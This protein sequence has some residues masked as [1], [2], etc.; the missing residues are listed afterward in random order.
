MNDHHPDNQISAWFDDELTAAERAS[1]KLRLE[2]SLDARDEL[3]EIG[4]ISEWLGELP[5]ESLPDGFTAGVE[6]L[7]ARSGAKPATIAH[8]STHHLRWSKGV[9][10]VLS[11][12]A[13]LFLTVTL[14]FGPER[15]DESPQRL[16][17]AT[18]EDAGSRDLTA[19]NGDRFFEMQ[20]PTEEAIV[21]FRNKNEIENGSR[22]IADDSATPS[23]IERFG[24]SATEKSTVAS[25]GR[26]VDA[27]AGGLTFSGNL[28]RAEIGQVVEALER[29]V[30]RVSVVRLTVVDRRE[31]LKN[32]QVLLSRNHI[33]Q[34]LTAEAD[35][36]QEKSRDAVAAKSALPNQD[37]RLVAVYVEATG[38]QL[39][40]VF[41]QIE[42]D[43]KFQP[44]K[45]DSPITIGQLAQATPAQFAFGG[46]T[47][48]SLRNRFN[49]AKLPRE[50]RAKGDTSR[51][52][53]PNRAAA[54]SAP[55]AVLNGKPANGKELKKT[56]SKDG[57]IALERRQQLAELERISRQLELNLA[58]AILAGK[59]SGQDPSE[60]RPLVE[61]L[62]K[63]KKQPGA[64]AQKL[65]AA[66]RSSASNSRRKEAPLQVLFVLEIVPPGD[67]ARPT[68]GQPAGSPAAPTKKKA[69]VRKPNGAA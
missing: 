14:F 46:R 15:A 65:E 52:P 9:G 12:A 7:T 8:G 11:V 21:G 16:P 36:Q 64:G 1:A 25:R 57:R 38:P 26:T 60:A 20:A 61:R 55:K 51:K 24:K 56:D 29:S 3:T 30:D 37:G 59:K 34:E 54:E 41:E 40:A 28:R 39:A 17:V 62:D 19:D 69:R 27:P 5:R 32:L 13:V 2:Q 49:E 23:P 48:R 4:K 45:I 42:Q 68:Q 63:Q 67:K 44:M 6:E 35:K 53:L 43:S 33:P 18:A 66:G 31:G 47:N 58:P 22:G 50:D 10:I